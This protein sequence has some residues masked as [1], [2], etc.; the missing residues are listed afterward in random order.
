M[1]TT[2][3]IQLPGPRDPFVR[4]VRAGWRSLTGGSAIRDSERGTLIACSGGAD[5]AAL[6]LALADRSPTVAH[7][8][9]DWRPAEQAWADRD[10]TQSLAERLQLAYVERHVSVRSERGNIESVARRERYRALC[11]LAS[12]RGLRFIATGHHADDQLE[13]LLLRLCRGAGVHGMRGIAPRRTIGAMEI[14]RP[15]LGVRR[16]ECEEFCTRCRYPWRVDATNDDMALARA[17]LRRRVLPA[18][19]EIEPRA[20]DNAVR[21]ARQMRRA[22]DHLHDQAATL[23][24]AAR[25]AEGRLEWE[26]P[27]LRGCDE[28]VLGQTLRLAAERIGGPHGS[29][30]R[31]ARP[32]GACV[33]AIR[34]AAGGRR[35]FEWGGVRV[36]VERE[37]VLMTGASDVE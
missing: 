30:R 19:I 23:L 2:G 9:H 33:R 34:D 22:A 13:T 21:V 18:L 20:P 6:V 27:T 15:M 5:S 14:I 29:D 4:R 28:W 1:T 17:A 24:E 3:A 36:V 31:G 37:Q 32:V 12:E 16:A 11:D 35:V 10:A 26:R 25:Q 8:V 7:V